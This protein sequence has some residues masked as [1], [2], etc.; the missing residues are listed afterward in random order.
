MRER[1]VRQYV[2]S[3]SPCANVR[4][5][6]YPPMFITTALQD[7]RVSPLETLKWAS[8]VRKAQTDHTRRV[9]VN[10]LK[11]S[12]HDGPSS[13]MEYLDNLALEIC[14]LEQSVAK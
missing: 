5:Q 10:V 3:Y 12:G 11:D 13:Q 14:F 7:T 2:R 6:A 8:L 1:E 9:V 4:A